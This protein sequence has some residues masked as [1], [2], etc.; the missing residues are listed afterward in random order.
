L[1]NFEDIYYLIN[2]CNFV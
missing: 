2:S 1:L